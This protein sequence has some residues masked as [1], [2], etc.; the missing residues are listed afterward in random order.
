MK[1]YL[2]RTGDCSAHLAAS[3]ASTH[4]MI[5][6]T[7]RLPTCDNQKCVQTFL[8]DHGGENYLQ[9]RVSN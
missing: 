6:S 9:R 2:G 4:P 3:L 8:N 7:L 5:A 1:E